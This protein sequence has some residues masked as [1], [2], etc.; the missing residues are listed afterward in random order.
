MTYSIREIGDWN[1]N[2]FSHLKKFN[3]TCKKK[4]KRGKKGRLGHKY[5]FC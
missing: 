3:P 1:G 5:C 4:E 2:L